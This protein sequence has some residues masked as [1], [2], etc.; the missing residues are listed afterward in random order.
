ME[1]KHVSAPK[2]LAQIFLARIPPIEQQPAITDVAARLT[3]DTDASTV[4]FLV[5]LLHL[6]RSDSADSLLKSHLEGS[7]DG[8]NPK[9]V[10]DVCTQYPA[11]RDWVLSQS[12]ERLAT[13]PYSS[14]DDLAN[15]YIGHKG[16]DAV[17][18]DVNSDEA[19]PSSI[20]LYIC[21]LRFLKLLFLGRTAGDV[22][23]VSDDIPTCLLNIAGAQVEA[24]SKAAAEA[25]YAFLGAL[26]DNQI[27]V[28]TNTSLAGHVW[29][30]IQILITSGTTR[31][32][33]IAY[34][35]WLRWSS[36]DG[37]HEPQEE[38]YREDKYWSL[39]QLGLRDG[40]SEQRKC[41]L[42]ILRRSL[43]K[44]AGPVN[45]SYMIIS[46]EY[47]KKDPGNNV[48]QAQY[49]KFCIL[50]E[51]I[52]FG[53]YLNQVE[54]CILDLTFLAT[55]ESLVHKT[56]LYTLLGPAL[57][58]VG[59]EG[60]RKLLGN[61]VM[62]A[63]I[64]AS[65]G[66]GS[67]MELLKVYFL[68]WATQGNLFTIKTRRDSA[69]A[70]CEHGNRLAGFLERLLQSCA[71]SEESDL[72]RSIVSTVLSYV[73]DRGDA[74]MA[75][76]GTY[77][78][79]GLASGLK[80][81]QA[82][83]LEWNDVQKLIDI[84]SRTNL[85]EIVRDFYVVRCWQLC[86]R[87]NVVCDLKRTS[88]IDRLRKRH[89][90][91][92]TKHATAI[93]GSSGP[94]HASIIQP[95]SLLDDFLQELRVTRYASL[96]GDGL[97]AACKKL[98]K[99]LGAHTNSQVDPVLLYEAL[100]AVWDEAEAQEYPRQIVLQVPGI[101]L[102]PTCAAL[103]TTN[104]GLRSLV[105]SI[106]VTLQ[107]LAEG[108][109][110]AFTPL[111][112]ALRKTT[113]STPELT[114]LLPFEEIVVQIAN[115]PPRA[116]VEFMLESAITCILTGSSFVEECGRHAST[117]TGEPYK[118]LTYE[119]YYGRNEA[120]GYAC[121]V[122]L[123]NRLSKCDELVT[124]RIL[125]RLLYPWVHQKHPV[126]VVTKWKTTLHL[127]SMLIVCEQLL[128]KMS[129]TK[130]AYYVESFREVLTVE[131]L[132][133]YRFLLEWILMRI[134]IHHG[135]T[136]PCIETI[137]STK[138]HH[139]N[140][141]YLASV[142]KIAVVLAC[143]EDAIEGFGLKIMSLV[144][145]L[146][147]S[148]KIVI[149]HEAQWSFPILWDH[150][151][152]QNWR[153]ITENPAFVAL[154]DYIRSLEQYAEPPKARELE[155]F[156]L[157]KD[158]NMTTLFQGGYLAIDP[159]EAPIVTS[160]DLERLAAEDEA[161]ASRFAEAC[162]PLR[163]TQDSVSSKCTDL[164]RTSASKSLIATAQ[165]EAPSAPPAL[166]TKGTAYLSQPLHS[167]SESTSRP[168]DLIVVGSL[169]SNPHN[170]GG[171]SRISEVFGAQALYVPTLSVLTN[172]DFTS[173]A[174]SSHHNIPIHA[175]PPSGLPAFLTQKKAQGFTVMGVEQTDRSIMLGDAGTV[176][177]RM[178]VLVMGAEKEGISAEVL[179]LCDVLIEIR[180]RGVTRSL[181][182][183]TAAGV[184]VYEY[185]RQHG[186]E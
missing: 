39:L 130:A 133:R 134:Y 2:L 28:V 51:T 140:P 174:V 46:T 156:V 41:C 72:R 9:P 73:H 75:H 84:A 71:R 111:M 127:Q 159:A 42:H 183:Q 114:C 90:D 179:G 141:K 79:E 67:L 91:I 182:V 27:S 11:L 124:Q 115:C 22:W 139:S 116:K 175:L 33:S 49:D 5:E 180:Q 23:P 55:P 97:L 45:T 96:R 153:Q 144:T 176:L 1:H 29:Q 24:L 62:R 107:T 36:L 160:E 74:L 155:R 92:L 177:P 106:L 158:H 151:L 83:C 89:D 70:L 53:R 32:R 66:A 86:Q 157:A 65:E 4:A 166:Q 18:V 125:D 118:H 104:D 76:A 121:F 58:P 123:L 154:N 119:R 37:H 82:P 152:Q 162:I 142:L 112:T 44:V 171:L 113:L 101:V 164:P 15:V 77:L 85:P 148:S 8:N 69:Q 88:G 126:P 132:P 7:I 170:L 47:N 94:S 64:R 120:H 54:E 102:H 38:L 135:E 20:S 149:R 185:G 184:V 12:K 93:E 138:D 59:Q 163:C 122:D 181:N 68:P 13:F 172:R 19:S 78:L 108:R 56:W 63:D 100:D 17:T 165:V 30:R 168:T 40:D 150:A 169:V 167:P 35:V 14:A 60:I 48:L 173:V 87:G 110:Y 128:P 57:A 21:Y 99:M 131:P 143:H 50:F 6:C 109:I 34:T 136:L 178:A 25:V 129:P 3:E 137:L 105:S 31:H 52:V 10:V 98:D 103:C 26:H 117:S 147:S 161:D 145:A 95:V 61:W 43:T 81:E 186:G 80:H 16:A 146:S